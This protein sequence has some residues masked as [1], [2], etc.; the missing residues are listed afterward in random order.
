MG[1]GASAATGFPDTGDN[2]S[3]LEAS[4]ELA[5]Y[6]GGASRPV[7]L[8]KA[9]RAWDAAVRRYNKRLWKFT[10]TETDHALGSVSA[11]TF[12]FTN[13]LGFR[14]PI[15]AQLLNSSGEEDDIVYWVNYEMWTEFSPEREA[16]QNAPRIYTAQ[17][18]HKDGKIIISPPTLAG[19]SMEHATLR[20]I[21]Y[22]YIALAKTPEA[23][24]NVPVDFDEGIFQ[25]ATAIFLSTERSFRESREAFALA[26][27]AQV[28]L[29]PEHRGYPEIE[30]F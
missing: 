29:W 7:I 8:D 1:S 18:T 26:L 6:V 14:G 5:D 12:E 10:R 11:G 4:R 2:R 20:L 25:L 30:A 28:E 17:N 23:K 9:G 15:R 27:A 3:R 13:S 24:L 16:N 21:H 19:A 22:I